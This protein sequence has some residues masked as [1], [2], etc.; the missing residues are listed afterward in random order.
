MVYYRVCHNGMNV[1]FCN[2]WDDVVKYVHSKIERS[3]SGEFIV[4]GNEIM[5]YQYRT[6]YQEMFHITHIEA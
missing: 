1:E 5:I 4:D 6:L 3:I 2:T